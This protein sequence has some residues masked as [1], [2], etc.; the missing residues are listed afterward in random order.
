F[1]A[2]GKLG[3]TP[4][5]TLD[6][7]YNTDFAQVEA[8]DQQ[9]N[10][11]RFNLFFPEKRPFFLENSGIFSVGT[12]EAVELFFSRPIGIGQDGSAVPILGGGRLTGKAGGLTLGL[13]DIQTERVKVLDSTTVSPDNYAVARVLRELPHRSRIG[14]IAVSRLNTD[15]TGDYNFVVGADGR[16]GLGE[17]AAIDGYFAHSV[18][19]CAA[20]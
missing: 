4:S 2:D 10:L 7:T 8:D 20:E 19:P 13:L 16:I 9:I 11:T 3:V 14:A 18:T 6:L 5:M 15:S 17:S 12:P 1:G